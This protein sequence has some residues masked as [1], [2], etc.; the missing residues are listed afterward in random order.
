LLQKLQKLPPLRSFSR[1][2]PGFGF[3]DPTPVAPV[4]GNPGTTL[5]Q[6]RMNAYRYVADIWE[7]NI[8]SSIEIKVSAAWEAL[9]CTAT[10]ATLGSASAMRSYRNFKGSKPNIWYPQALANK[11]AGEN[12]TDGRIDTT[13]WSNFDI[14]TQFN[15]N[16]GNSNCLSGSGFYLRL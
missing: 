11:I 6:Q 12:L 15:I 13:G 7:R 16:L 9:T 8:E 1:D 10:S 2:A 4:G 14:K 3:N 5:G